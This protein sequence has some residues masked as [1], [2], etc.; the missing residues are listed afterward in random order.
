MTALAVMSAAG[1]TRPEVE[2]D[3]VVVSL[4][5]VAMVAEV[6]EDSD[7]VSRVLNILYEGIRA[8]T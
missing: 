1:V 2:P 3:D 8:R 7:Q 4:S 6:L 5:G